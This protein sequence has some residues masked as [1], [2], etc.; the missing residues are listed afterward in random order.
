MQ[1]CFKY[2]A[3]RVKKV[4]MKFSPYYLMQQSY[5]ERVSHFLRILMDSYL[6]RAH[7]LAGCSLFCFSASST[8]IIDQLHPK[9]ALA[10][11]SGAQGDRVSSS[12]VRHWYLEREIIFDKW[13]LSAVGTPEQKKKHT[14]TTCHF[15]YLYL[16]KR[17]GLQR[18]YCKLV[19][20]LDSKHYT[21]R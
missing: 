9:L 14:S 1:T 3:N 5:F 7:E 12:G 20:D 13:M 21:M 16:G 8:G 2:S 11:R 4:P 17:Y 19:L 6:K 18:I 10:N 15:F